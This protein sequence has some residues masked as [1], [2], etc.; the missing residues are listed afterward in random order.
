MRSYP[1]H[2]GVFLEPDRKAHIRLLFITMN[3]TAAEHEVFIKHCVF[4]NEEFQVITHFPEDKEEYLI[5]HVM[6]CVVNSTLIFPTV[7]LNCISAMTILRNRQ[8]KEKASYF[9]ISIQSIVD[10]TIGVLVLPSLVFIIASEIHGSPNCSAHFLVFKATYMFTA[11]S[12]LTLCAMT[13]ERY[14]GI[15]RP[16]IH[17]TSLTNAR[18]LLGICGGTLWP[19]LSLVGT[20]VYPRFYRVSSSIGITLFLSLNVY[21]YGKIWIF[22]KSSRRAISRGVNCLTQTSDINE[23]RKIE[24]ET[25]LAKSCFLV[26]LC[27]VICLLPISFNSVYQ[28]LEIFQNRVGYLWSL[29]FLMFNSVLNSLIF[30][31]RNPLL[32]RSAA[33]FNCT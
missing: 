5:N 17:R 32:A 4:L 19:F 2:A 14:L 13:F 8:L 25:K 9:L 15:F 16:L 11:L 30:F 27:C 20:I 18:L 23:R 24:R 10:A 1:G 7:F 3:A 22:V 6:L 31:W 21:V 28:N 33:F 29:T 26:I 12:A